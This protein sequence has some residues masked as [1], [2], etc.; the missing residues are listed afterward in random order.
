MH[1]ASLYPSIDKRRPA[2]SPQG[3]DGVGLSQLDDDGSG[4]QLVA[5]VA[6]VP[7]VVAGVTVE[8][9]VSAAAHTLD[10]AGTC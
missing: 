7:V 8:Q 1:K 10:D 6:R 3:A 9:G 4:T 5:S 2:L